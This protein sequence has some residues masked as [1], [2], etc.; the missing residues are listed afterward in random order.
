M[1]KYLHGKVSANHWL[2]SS[3]SRLS[4]L[5]HPGVLL[6]RS[7]GQYVTEPEEI[8]P[9]LL[10][11]VTRINAEVAFTM[12]TETTHV[13]FSN[14]QPHQTEVVFPRGNQLQ[15]VD[16]LG[17]IVRTGKIKKF[18]YA[19]LVREERVLLVWHDDLDKILNHAAS[20]EE[21]LL[22]LVRLHIHL[23]AEILMLILY[24]YGELASLHLL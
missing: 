14:L 17:D 11:A 7:R 3:D 24:R 4:T 12:A 5:G 22:A 20:V 1:I 9:I 18:Q 13:I 19:A 15:V 8:D 23:T 10:A 16:S 2:H 21:K 6:R